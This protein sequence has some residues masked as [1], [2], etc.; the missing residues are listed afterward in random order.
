M[1]NTMIYMFIK[2]STG[3][4]CKEISDVK[5][6]END[7]QDHVDEGEIIAI[8]DDIEYFADEMNINVDDIN[9]V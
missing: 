1:E 5:S 2:L 8:G 9:M 7:I 6:Y 3:W 4:F